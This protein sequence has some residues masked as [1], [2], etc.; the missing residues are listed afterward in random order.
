MKRE[1][2]PRRRAEDVAGPPAPTVLV[3]LDGSASATA[4]LPV[5]RTLAGLLRATLHVI[6]VAPQPI[7]EAEIPERLRLSPEQLHDAVVD[8]REGDP[9]PNIL[10]VV[11]GQPSSTVLVLCTHTGADHAA[12]GL[13]RVAEALLLDAPCPLLFV[14]PER[15]MAPWVLHRALLPHDGTPTTAAAFHPAA[16]LARRADAELVVLHAAAPGEARPA[17]P[18][19]YTAPLYV[20][21]PQHEW[22]SWAWEFLERVGSLGRLPSGLKLRLFLARGDPG[23]TIIDFA[24]RNPVDLIILAWHGR[25]EPERALTVK[26]V[27]RQAPCPVLIQRVREPAPR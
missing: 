14:Q 3:P 4:A 17:E 23:S 2:T 19:T 9:I 21:Q 18:G 27:L 16:D 10:D 7:P 8:T 20:D 15:G 12:G 22:P 1:P 5:A 11:A 25:R 6:H 26:T 13:G 24:R